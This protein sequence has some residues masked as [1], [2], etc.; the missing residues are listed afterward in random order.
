MKRLS[1]TFMTYCMDINTC[2]LT[3]LRDERHNGRDK[4]DEI[5]LKLGAYLECQRPYLPNT[6]HK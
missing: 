5:T 2:N 4:G 6:I 1:E 3:L